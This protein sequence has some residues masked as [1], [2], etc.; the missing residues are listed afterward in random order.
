M[1]RVFASFSIRLVAVLA[2]ALSGTLAHAQTLV[3]PSK[4]APEFRQQAEKRRAEQ[5][6]QIFCNKEAIDQKI[7]PRDKPQF[8]IDCFDKL[9]DKTSSPPSD[10]SATRK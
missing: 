5:L 10:I 7:A 9:D 4:V 8:V 2:I 6:K 1:R 3:D